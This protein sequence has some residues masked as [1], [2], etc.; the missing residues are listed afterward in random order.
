MRPAPP[1][2]LDAAN[3]FLSERLPHDLPVVVESGL[4]FEQGMLGMTRRLP[5][6]YLITIDPRLDGYGQGMVLI[7]EWAHVLVWDTGLRSHGVEWGE[8]YSRVFQIWVN[9]NS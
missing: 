3:E 5:G 7:H 4:L 8:A 1:P 6:C 9:E 2:G